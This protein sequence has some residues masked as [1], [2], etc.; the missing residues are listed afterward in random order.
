MAK[1]GASIKEIESKLQ[2]LSDISLR[3]NS[4]RCAKKAKQLE[5]A[6]HAVLVMRAGPSA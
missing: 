2:D 1:E 4:C 5:T 6:S 3:Q